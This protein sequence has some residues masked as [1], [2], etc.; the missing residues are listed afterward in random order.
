M[1]KQSTRDCRPLSASKD[2]FPPSPAP[3]WSTTS[4]YSFLQ[5]P[6]WLHTFPSR[7]W[8]DPLSSWALAQNNKWLTH[9]LPSMT[10][11]LLYGTLMHIH[12]CRRWFWDTP[13]WCYG[14]SQFQ[15]PHPLQHIFPQRNQGL[16][17][18]LSHIRSEWYFGI[19]HLPSD[20]NLWHGAKAPF[21]QVLAFSLSPQITFHVLLPSK[22]GRGSLLRYLP[23]F[24]PNVHQRPRCHS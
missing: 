8:A 13:S 3:A 5:Q 1:H 2:S 24:H 7:I 11:I 18:S 22:P 6:S 4:S 10:L 17:C 16:I 20:C 14:T 15:L 12:R 23:F 9:G 21:R 19:I